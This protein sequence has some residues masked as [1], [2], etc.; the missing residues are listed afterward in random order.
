MSSNATSDWATGGRPCRADAD[1]QERDRLRLVELENRIDEAAP[2]ESIVVDILDE[3][4]RHVEERGV[5]REQLRMSSEQLEAT[6]SELARERQRIADLFDHVPFGHMVT[7]VD[8]TIRQTN[9]A[10]AELL[11]RDADTLIGQSLVSFVVD[12]QVTAFRRWLHG[13]PDRRRPDRTS[14]TVNGEGRPARVLDVFTVTEPDAHEQ[15]GT[16]RWVLASRNVDAADLAATAW[17]FE[18][19]SGERESLRVAAVGTIRLAA[20]GLKMLLQAMVPNRDITVSVPA[21]GLTDIDHLIEAAP[22][23]AL[24]TVGTD[25]GGIDLIEEVTRRSETTAVLTVVPADDGRLTRRAA[26]AGARGVITTDT[27]LD[28]LATALLTVAAGW[29]VL[30]AEV[31]HFTS[32]PVAPQ[33]DADSRELWKLV[34]TG[35]SDDA[36]AERW[37]VSTRTIKRRVSDLYQQ[38]DVEGR[39]EAAALAGRTGMLDEP[40]AE[41]DTEEDTT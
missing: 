24:V 30:P 8:G 12:S 9:R 35:T 25:G 33:L 39:V 40:V 32:P 17:P 10:A 26:A 20:T 22:D 36:I 38:L 37:N 19:A 18:D 29:T 1:E 11:G 6:A 7:D 16:V 23:V 3:A 41:R 28:R 2:D 4:R 5:L 34:A 31:R 27:D 14:L 15:R 21:D 13:L